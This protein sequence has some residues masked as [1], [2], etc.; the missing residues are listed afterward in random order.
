[1]VTAGKIFTLVL[2]GTYFA[3][4]KFRFNPFIYN[5]L[6]FFWLVVRR[7]AIWHNNCFFKGEVITM[8][9]DKLLFSDQTP[10]VLKK[11]WTFNLRVI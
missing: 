1:M 5:G 10:L 4:N 3:M 2:G 9:I 6:L 11:A 8:L 7:G